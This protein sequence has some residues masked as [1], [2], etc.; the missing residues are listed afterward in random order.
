MSET[1]SYAEPLGRI[2]S[3]LFI[4]T[5]R[6]AEQETGMLAS[7]VVQAGFEP[8]AVSVAVRRDRYVTQWLVPGVSFVLN[9]LS[10]G[11]KEFL[12]HFGKGFEPGESA[13][14]GLSI[15]RTADGV[16]ILG[17]TLGH[18]ECTVLTHADSGDHRIFIAQVVGGRLLQDAPPYVHIRKNG[19]RY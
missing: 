5:A 14:Q 17:N 13:F 19:L 15:E 2:P 3:G 1:P 8:P 11:N 4:L 12:K 9:L 10:E 6:H 18:L 7:W 16:V